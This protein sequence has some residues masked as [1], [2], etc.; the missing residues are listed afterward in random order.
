MTHRTFWFLILRIEFNK[1]FCTGYKNAVLTFENSF[2]SSMSHHNIHNICFH[3]LYILEEIF[4]FFILNL[5]MVYNNYGIIY[6]LKK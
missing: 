1:I 3:F 4:V 2:P 6:F 5:K